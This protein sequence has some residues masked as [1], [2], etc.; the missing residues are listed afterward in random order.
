MNTSSPA[1]S[2]SQSGE[3]KWFDSVKGYGFIKQ[4][5]GEDVFIHINELRKSGVKAVMEGAKVSF[6][7]NSGPKGAFATNIKVDQSC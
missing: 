5:T 3:I 7:P 6:T 1:E 2:S 4:S